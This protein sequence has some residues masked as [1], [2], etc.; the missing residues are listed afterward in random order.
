MADFL[1][2]AGALQL[3]ASIRVRGDLRQR[4]DPEDIVQETCIRAYTRYHGFDPGQ[5][6]FRA[7][8]FGI[9]TKVLLQQLRA[10]RGQG[11]SL[12]TQEPRTAGDRWHPQRMQSAGIQRPEV[13]ALLDSVSSITGKI[14][15]REALA[16]VL[17]E[18][19]HLGREERW[20]LLYRGLER[21]E[22]GEIGERLGLH[23]EAVRARWRRLL[24]RLRGRPG[25]KRFLD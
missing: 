18:V 23:P 10:L 25:L 9:A 7:W 4:I 1:A 11:G 13:E 20:L 14:A 24:E 21:L 15:E 8:V 3:W 17:E 6:T 16:A 12:P 22:F 19:G 2:V 5:G